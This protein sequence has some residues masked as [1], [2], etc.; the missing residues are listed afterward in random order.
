MNGAMSAGHFASGVDL[1]PNFAGK[2]FARSVNLAAEQ[3]Y[4][5][6]SFVWNVTLTGFS[7][8]TWT[9]VIVIN[10]SCKCLLPSVQDE[11]SVIKNH[12]KNCVKQKKLFVLFGTCFRDDLY[13]IS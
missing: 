1:A 9:M 11:M 5:G 10:L 6:L 3:T 13:S 4:C 7:L 8:A 12:W 2:R